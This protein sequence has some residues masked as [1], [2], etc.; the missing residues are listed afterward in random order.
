MLVM[1]KWLTL[2][3]ISGW[4]VYILFC[5]ILID[6]IRYYFLGILQRSM[7]ILINFVLESLFKYTV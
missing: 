1:Y 6:L 5:Q 3:L 7:V 4:L 2:C